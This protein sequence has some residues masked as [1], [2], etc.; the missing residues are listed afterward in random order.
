MPGLALTLAQ[1]C[2]LWSLDVA[3]CIARSLSSP[4][5]FLCRK[6]DGGYGRASDLRFARAW[7]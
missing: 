7:R 4:I 3:T 1:A 2:R 6:G 5:G